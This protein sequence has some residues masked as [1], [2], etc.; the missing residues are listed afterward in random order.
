MTFEDEVA[1]DDNGIARLFARH[2]SSVYSTDFTHRHDALNFEA[3]QIEDPQLL[4]VPFT[5]QEVMSA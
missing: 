2:F 3:P 5:E 4:N 1:E